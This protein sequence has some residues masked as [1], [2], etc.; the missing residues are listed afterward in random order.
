MYLDAQ[1]L[2]HQISPSAASTLTAFV[3]LQVVVCQVDFFCS[4]SRSSA[5][6]LKLYLPAA[7]GAMQGPMW[8]ASP[9][10]PTFS[11]LW[12][13]SSWDKCRILMVFFFAYC[14][15]QLSLIQS[16][17]T[18]SPWSFLQKLLRKKASS[19][20][21]ELLR[22]M[23][24]NGN[25]SGHLRVLSMFH[26]NNRLNLNFN[27]KKRQWKEIRHILINCFPYNLSFDER[28]LSPS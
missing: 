7:P 13:T 1:C 5:S 23:S 3:R 11:A 15:F 2:A 9:Q 21:P 8:P 22:K 20:L 28:Y 4:Y 16:H 12:W 10:T 25:I 27:M 18:Q 24:C 17:K 26:Q 14:I 6:M 19:K